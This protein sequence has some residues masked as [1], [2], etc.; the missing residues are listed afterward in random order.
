MAAG[1]V[2]QA[3]R[4]TGRTGAEHSVMEQTL[5]TALSLTAGP[6]HRPSVAILAQVGLS[7]SGF[8]LP[9]TPTSLFSPRGHVHVRRGPVYPTG[10]AGREL[11]TINSVQTYS[12]GLSAQID[13][14]LQ[15]P[16]GV[17]SKPTHSLSPR[18][19]PGWAV[20]AGRVGQADRPTSRT[21]AEQVS[22]GAD[23]P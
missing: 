22:D 19:G 18:P 15:L 3:D 2:G 17:R 14:I 20:A 4:P 5:V 7:F 10:P 9:P 23:T 12:F 11:C 8:D 21:G 13:V 16:R 1:R 6:E